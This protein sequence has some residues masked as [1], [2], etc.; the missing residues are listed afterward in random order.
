M[1]KCSALTIQLSLAYSLQIETRTLAGHRKNALPFPSMW[2][3]LTE[4]ISFQRKNLAFRPSNKYI[5]HLSLALHNGK[6]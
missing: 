1:L 5:L 6:A 4:K 2:N 3:T